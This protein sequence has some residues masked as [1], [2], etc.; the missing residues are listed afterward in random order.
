[1][2]VNSCHLTSLLSTGIE[3]C[4][5][6]L[7]NI[8]HLEVNEPTGVDR[9]PQLT[10]LRRLHLKG[11]PPVNCDWQWLGSLD[12]LTDID[13]SIRVR[14]RDVGRLQVCDNKTKCLGIS[15][16]QVVPILVTVFN[17]LPRVM[18]KKVSL[19]LRKCDPASQNQ[20]KKVA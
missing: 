12:D 14:A 15:E 9:F 5:Q 7:P 18:R 10:T 19:H 3:S 6:S 1:M 2:R 20:Q 4:F 13:V 11:I 17:N 16:D 8:D